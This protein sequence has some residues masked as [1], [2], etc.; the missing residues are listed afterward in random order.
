MPK[1]QI[2]SANETSISKCL[3]HLRDGELVAL[4]TETV[5]GLAADA[6]NGEAVARIFKTKGRPQFNPLI[7]HIDSLKHAQKLGVFSDIALKLA[8]VFWPG[9]LTL[10]VPKTDNCP[11]HDLVTAGLDTIAIRWPDAVFATDLIRAFDKPLAAPSANKS[12]RL[13][14]TLAEH[15]MAD[16][17]GEIPLIIDN[18]P[19]RAGLE[20]TI[21]SIIGDDVIL[22]RQGAITKEDIEQLLG[23]RVSTSTNNDKAPQ[24]PGML[25]RHYAPKAQLRL[26]ADTLEPHEA[27]LGFGP[28]VSEFDLN[29]SSK[30]D[31]TE[32]A[33]NLFA[34]LHELDKHHDYIAVAPIPDEGLGVA[35]NDR[36]KRAAET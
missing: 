32:A 30:G 20:S 27:Y 26:N 3:K 19:C 9:P 13:S 29:L 6:T 25:L 16:F 28:H 35:I 15:V 1:T 31:L 33:A 17:D 36:L 5:Y 8:D 21:L 4:P 12:G 10:V 11:V 23:H 24:A 14:P 7:S 34:F 2:L 18:G 22:L